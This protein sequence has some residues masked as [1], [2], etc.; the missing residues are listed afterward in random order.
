[1][2]EPHLLTLRSSL[3]S[4]EK[5]LTSPGKP[6]RLGLISL[7]LRGRQRREGKDSGKTS[8]A[9]SLPQGQ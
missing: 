4:Q 3:E 5:Q 9:S 8:W 7:G 6:G 1:M 2:R